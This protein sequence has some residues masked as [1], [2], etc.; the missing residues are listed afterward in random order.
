MCGENAE[1][2]A[3]PPGGRRQVPTSASFVDPSFSSP[4]PPEK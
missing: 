3:V 1:K 4:S 2:F